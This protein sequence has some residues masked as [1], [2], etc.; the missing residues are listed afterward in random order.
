MANGTRRASLAEAVALHGRIESA[1]G[2][3]PFVLA[4]N[5]ADLDH[6]WELGASDLSPLE[7]AGGV[8][9]R[10]SARTGNGVEDA[11]GQLAHRLA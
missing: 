6:E 2:A 4:L 3:L 1:Y 5:K 8:L 7:A 10:T 9:V 11:F